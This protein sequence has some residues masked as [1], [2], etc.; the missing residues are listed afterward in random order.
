MAKLYKFHRMLNS[1]Q[2][3][4]CRL[5]AQQNTFYWR[6]M[7]DLPDYVHD[8]LHKIAKAEYFTGDYHINVKP[9]C[10]EG[11]GFLGVIASVNITGTRAPNNDALHL[12]CKLAP[13]SA[14][15]REGFGSIALFKREAYMYQTVLPQLAAFERE[16]GLTEAN[17]F[18]AYPKCYEIIADEEKDQF[19]L[20]MEDMRA[21][22]YTMW[23]RSQPIPVN[24][25]N[26]VLQQLA[27]MHAISFALKDQRP[28][29]YAGFKAV[30]DIVVDF[31][32]TST[33]K[34]VIEA[35]YVR[36][37]NAAEEEK[38]IEIIKDISA[39]NNEY[40]A[41]CVT[42]EFVGP[43][44]VITHGDCWINNLLFHNR[45]EVSNQFTSK[46]TTTT[47]AYLYDIS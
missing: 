10:D 15:R 44:A 29:I 26:S 30:T 31:M 12:V 2:S 7:F 22:G 20:I 33:M 25:V 46:V 1:N 41:E 19:V 24:Y 35:S 37:L 16:K 21:K 32:K 42:D 27:R 8:L 9:G 3:A 47:Y 18:T 40:Y 45:N 6:K 39:N 36:C 13:T 43:Y 14:A 5:L 38:H 4:L 17:R 11:D 34:V 28:K 23:D